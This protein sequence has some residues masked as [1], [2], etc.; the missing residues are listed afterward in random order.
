MGAACSSP[1]SSSGGDGKTSSVGQRARR[2]LVMEE[3]EKKGKKGGRRD[4][5][6]RNLYARHAEYGVMEEEVTWDPWMA[7]CLPDVLRREDDGDWMTGRRMTSGT[8]QR[9]DFR[10]TDE[11]ANRRRP[12]LAH[13]LMGLG[14]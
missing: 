6:Q 5:Q 8:N 14:P 10:R 7:L 12:W 1:V 2:W 4:G 3:D 9:T 11:P 13:S